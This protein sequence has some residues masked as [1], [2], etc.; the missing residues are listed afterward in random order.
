MEDYSESNLLTW[1]LSTLSDAIKN[2]VVSPLDVVQQL[3]AHIEKENLKV[4]AFI[5]VLQQDAMKQAKDAAD[6][7]ASGH[8]KGALHGVP[9][10]LKDLIYT[11]NI[12]TTMGSEI[13]KDFIPDY[14]ATVV[15]ALDQAGAI[16][17][18]KLNTHQFAY[19]PIGDRSY[20]GPTRNPF[21]PS[22]ISG[23]SS[24]GS[25]AAIATSMCY[26][27]LGTDTGGSIRI[28]ASCCGIVG[29]KPTF[30]RV[31]KYGVYPLNYTVDTIGPMTKTV[32]DNAMLLTVLAGYDTRDPYSLQTEKEDFTRFLYEGV[33]G[34]K[35]GIPASYYNH[36]LQDEVNEKIE[37]AKRVFEHL[38]AELSTVDMP[39]MDD[40]FT[41]HQ[42]VSRGEAYTVHE[43]LLEKHSDQYEEEVKDR[44]LANK[45][46]KAHEYVQAEQFRHTAKQAFHDALQEVDV[47]LT[48]T[49]PI[50]PTNL[51]QRE[52]T[53]HGQTES[54]RTALLRLTAPTSFNGFPSISIPCGFAASGLPIGCQLIGSPLKEARLY[55]YAH[56]FEQER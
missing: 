2:K 6:D 36:H 34:V 54:I 40:I 52:V 13:Y 7:I 18:G 12:K 48:P 27:A 51:N 56:A 17:V 44:L 55:Q 14:D 4:N 3:F 45:D 41:A 30:G 39:L 22:K 9:I 21:D 10:G 42:L 15:E 8:W 20:F 49:I 37:D 23:G 50:L 43:K 26:G 33:K 25:A 19:G 35:I 31:S 1:S 16:I 46:I 29:M 32:R 47:L 28:P 24:S 53:F 5:S 11:K 38:G